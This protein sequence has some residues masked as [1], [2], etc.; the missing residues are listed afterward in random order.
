MITESY[1][2]GM[3]CQEF[4]SRVLQNVAPR[5]TSEQSKRVYT[6]Y[7]KRTGHIGR[8]LNSQNFS[9]VKSGGI[10]ELRMNY[11]IDL[12][13]LDMKTTKYGRK[14][15]YGPVYNRPLWGYV[16][17]YTFG[18]LRYGFTKKIKTDIIDTIRESYENSME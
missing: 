4:V 9:V 18:T 16:Y 2:H 5:I 3:A 15:I 12:R 14:K 6:Y 8:Q 13:F 1:I 10:N 7:N 11:L 17:G